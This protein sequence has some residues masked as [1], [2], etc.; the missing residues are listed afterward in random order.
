MTGPLVTYRVRA[1]GPGWTAEQLQ[2]DFLMVARGDVSVALDLACRALA[3]E[4]T[5]GYHRPPPMSGGAILSPDQGE[6][7]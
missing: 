5:G 1:S 3:K 2:A 4:T 7:L 6:A